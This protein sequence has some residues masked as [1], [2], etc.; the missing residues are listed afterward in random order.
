VP[1]AVAIVFGTVALAILMGVLTRWDHTLSTYRGNTRSII[2][3]AAT[4]VLLVVSVV[5]GAYA[6]AEP[7]DDHL[8]A[9]P[10]LIVSLGVTWGLM[11]LIAPPLHDLFDALR[12]S[13]TK[14]AYDRLTTGLS[15]LTVVGPVVF[16]ALTWPWWVTFLWIWTVAVTLLIYARVKRFI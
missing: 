8:A 9:I 16:T 15:V 6:V 10:T 3:L 14:T 5:I 4:L 1:N 7:R 11:S 13:M 12:E 2:A